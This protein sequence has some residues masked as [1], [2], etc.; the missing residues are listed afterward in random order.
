MRRRYTREWYIQQAASELLT[1]NPRIEIPSKPNVIA[2][3]AR[4][5]PEAPRGRAGAYVQAWVWV[6]GTEYHEEGDRNRQGGTV[7]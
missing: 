3:D 4:G 2:F 1:A 6:D 7:L 5:G